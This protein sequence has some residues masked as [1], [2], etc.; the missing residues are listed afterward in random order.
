M[1]FSVFD[2]SLDVEQ[3]NPSY[4][5]S[6]IKPFSYINFDGYQTAGGEQMIVH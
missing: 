5:F 2:D 1:D 6:P 4:L 3:W